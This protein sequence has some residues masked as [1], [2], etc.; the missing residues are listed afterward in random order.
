[1]P[2]T[3]TALASKTERQTRL[4]RAAAKVASN[5]KHEA[6]KESKLKKPQRQ[7]LSTLAKLKTGEG[8]SRRGIAD[9]VAKTDSVI[10][11]RIANESKTYQG[12][13]DDGFIKS[14]EIGGPGEEINETIYFITAAGKKAIGK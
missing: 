6:T 1:M 3:K 4:Q 13:L 7:V 14:K 5:G 9:K 8:L 12:L 11:G 10:N 2:D